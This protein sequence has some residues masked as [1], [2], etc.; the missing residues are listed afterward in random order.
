MAVAG[1][2]IYQAFFLDVPDPLGPL[3]VGPKV[4]IYI[5]PSH[6]DRRSN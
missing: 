6:G 3:V 5:A 2:E 4:D 1:Q